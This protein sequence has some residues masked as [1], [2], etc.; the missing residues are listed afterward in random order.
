M[1]ATSDSDWYS[2]DAA[3]FGDR[4]TGAREARGMTRKQLAERLGVRV[5]T[6]ESWEEDRAD[7]RANKLQML[8]GVL[9]VSLMWLLTGEGDGVDG[10]LD[11]DDPGAAA[12]RTVLDEARQIRAEIGALAERMGRLEKR[13]RVLISE[14]RP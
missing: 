5:K 4:V 3:T 2:S 9:G 8:A 13:L 12:A 1:D 11:P 14:A 7:P 6:L 10:P